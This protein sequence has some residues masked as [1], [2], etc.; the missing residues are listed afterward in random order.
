M[1]FTGQILLKTKKDNSISRNI[2]YS[3]VVAL[4]PFSFCWTWKCTQIHQKK[5]D[6]VLIWTYWWTVY[7]EEYKSTDL[8]VIENV[9][10]LT[11]DHIIPFRLVRWKTLILHSLMKGTLCHWCNIITRTM[12]MKELINETVDWIIDYVLK[13]LT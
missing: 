6:D 5:L 8:H 9:F 4:M 1:N 2:L 11:S 7:F 10:Y 12:R 13:L 3:R